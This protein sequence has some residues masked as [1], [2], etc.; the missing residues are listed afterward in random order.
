MSL[1]RKVLLC[2]LGGQSFTS[3]ANATPQLHPNTKQPISS[4]SGW[5]RNLS[6]SLCHFSFGW[7][8]YLLPF[9]IEQYRKVVA[10]G[11]HS[12]TALIDHCFDLLLISC[13]LNSKAGHQILS[14]P[15]GLQHCDI[16][17]FVALVHLQFC[18]VRSISANR[19]G[20]L[21]PTRMHRSRVLRETHILFTRT[22]YVFHCCLSFRGCGYYWHR[23]TSTSFSGE[24]WL[25]Y[26]IRTR[27]VN[28]TFVSKR[29]RP[30]YSDRM[31]TVILTQKGHVD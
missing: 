31:K 3:W 15:S 30:R 10:N 1:P 20:H 24:M 9:W 7:Y 2:E 8:I 14:V 26:T 11:I 27:A 29:I 21:S 23:F 25:H 12:T 13:W 22:I 19:S 6:C 17:S 16:S 4:S 18:F 28:C 5:Y